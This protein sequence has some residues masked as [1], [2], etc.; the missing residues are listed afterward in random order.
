MFKLFILSSLLLTSAFASG[1]IEGEIERQALNIPAVI[2]FLIFVGGTL[3]ITYWAAKRTKT[4]KDFYTAGG[5][6]AVFK[7]VWQLLVIICL[8]LL[9]WV[10]PG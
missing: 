6:L 7:M 3:M 9:F 8:Q 4:A 1:T 10:F 2:M 5:V